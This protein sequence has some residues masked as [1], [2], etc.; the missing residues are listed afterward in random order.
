MFI[1]QAKKLMGF[2]LRQFLPAACSLAYFLNIPLAMLDRIFDH[3]CLR[4]VMKLSLENIKAPGN[5]IGKNLVVF[6]L[7]F[8]GQDSW[9]RFMNM[10]HDHESWSEFR[11]RIQGQDSGSGFR[12]RIQGQDFGP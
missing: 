7:R 4:R 12:V 1:Q 8:H 2:V 6:T 9:S 10:F 11:A 5:I 3:F